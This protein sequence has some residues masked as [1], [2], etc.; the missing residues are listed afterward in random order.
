MLWSGVLVPPGGRTRLEVHVKPPGGHATID[1]IAGVVTLTGD[2]GEPEGVQP[3]L[4]SFHVSVDP[5]SLT[6]VE[7]IPWAN[8][9]SPKAWLHNI[10]GGGTVQVTSPKDGCVEF[11]FAFDKT[12]T[13]AW[14]YPVLEFNPL[15]PA[16]ADGVR[17]SIEGVA[18]SVPITQLNVI[19]FDAKGAQYIVDTDTQV[20]VTDTSPQLVTV[21]TKDAR[22]DGFGPPGTSIT[23]AQVSRL[24]V[25]LNL[26][27]HQSTAQMTVCSMN[28]VRF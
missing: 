6:P 25:G 12:T 1:E 16:N 13:D 9:T 20:N 22:Y 21:L 5:R 7:Q 27:Q 18:S 15:P 10:A 19:F 24:A 17:Y 2:F 14:A 4:L 3:P 23:T 28:W 26:G 11:A 8:A